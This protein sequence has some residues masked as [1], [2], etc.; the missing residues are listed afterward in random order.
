MGVLRLRSPE[1][2][3]LGRRADARQATATAG[4]GK[5]WSGDADAPAQRTGA[6]GALLGGGPHS[7]GP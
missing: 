1:G 6:R 3:G 4:P 5:V 7:A 2:A